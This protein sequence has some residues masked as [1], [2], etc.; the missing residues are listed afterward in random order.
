MAKEQTEV[1]S[2]R[3]PISTVKR[4]DDTARKV[5]KIRS[6]FVKEVFMSNFE[7]TYSILENKRKRPKALA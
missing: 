3:V 6:T 2:F 1:I 7:T 5:R 4:I